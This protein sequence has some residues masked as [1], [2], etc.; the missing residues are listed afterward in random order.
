MSGRGEAA[1]V[2]RTL[3]LAP[4]SFHPPLPS[5]DARALRA[6]ARLQRDATAA[7]AAANAAAAATQAE[8][9]A[10]AAARRR[11]E[12]AARS[13]LSVEGGFFD[14]FGSSDR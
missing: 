2:Q 1:D 7:R 8:Q 5:Y 14:R 4:S 11:A 10:A 3:T 12:A 13:S 6:A 9:A